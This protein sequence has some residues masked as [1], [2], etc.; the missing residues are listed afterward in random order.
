MHCSQKKEW[1]TNGP[2][3]PVDDATK[4][5]GNLKDCSV[6]GDQVRLQGLIRLITLCSDR[7]REIMWPTAAVIDD[8]AFEIFIA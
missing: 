5:N 7:K 4:R 1:L 2:G 6:P 3:W 8:F